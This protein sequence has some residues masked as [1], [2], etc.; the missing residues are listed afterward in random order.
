MR[1][2]VDEYPEVF[3]FSACVFPAEDDDVVTSPYNSVLATN[4]LIEHADCVFPIDNHALQ[5][6]AQ[7]EAS[8]RKTKKAGSDS[9]AD[10]GGPPIAGIPSNKGKRAKERG[11]DDMNAVAAR[12]LTHLTASSRFNGE[13]NVDM[14]EICTNLV[15]YPRLHFLMTALSPQRAVSGSSSSAHAH[16]LS[17]GASSGRGAMQRAFSDILSRSGQISGSDPAEEGSIT[18][19]SAFITRGRV[20]LSDFLY[21]VTAAQRSLKFPAWNPDACKVRIHHIIN[22]F[23]CSK[24]SIMLCLCCRLACAAR[25]HPESR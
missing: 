14:N 15:P 21:C 1:I 12:M 9:A 18:V 24:F 10:D 25:L 19:S 22:L 5:I 23:V 8:Q 16:S 6:F 13:M 3:R 4:Q 11:F 7:L 17:R 2:C 20:S